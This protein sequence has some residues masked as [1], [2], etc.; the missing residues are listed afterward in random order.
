MVGVGVVNL[1]SQRGIG[2]IKTGA[3]FFGQIL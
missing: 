3:G 1:D 2:R